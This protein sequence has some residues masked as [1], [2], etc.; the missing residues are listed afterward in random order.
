MLN[1]VYK[2]YCH[3]E[4]KVYSVTANNDSYVED[5]SGTKAKNNCP[6]LGWR[7]VQLKLSKLC[8]LTCVRV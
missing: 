5:P 6:S 3:F 1:Y 8:V 4:Y 2:I 7:N